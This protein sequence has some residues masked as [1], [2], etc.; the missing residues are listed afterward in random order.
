VGGASTL[1]ESATIKNQADAE[2]DYVLQAGATASQK[3]LS[4]QRLE[5]KQ[6]WYMVKNTTNDWALNSAT[7]GLDSFKVLPE[8]QQRRHLHRRVERL[9]SGAHQ[10]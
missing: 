1:A 5:R 6:Q 10:L 4:L 3:N 2:I 9:R 8:H 7:G